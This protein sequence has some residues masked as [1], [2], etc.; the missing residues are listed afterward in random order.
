VN[1][2]HEVTSWEELGQWCWV[3]M[4]CLR[5]IWQTAPS[6]RRELPSTKLERSIDSCIRSMLR[7]PAHSLVA[8]EEDKPWILARLQFGSGL[9]QPS[10]VELLRL[11]KLSDPVDALRFLLL[12][13]WYD[14]GREFWPLVCDT[15]NEHDNAFSGEDGA[16]R[17]LSEVNPRDEDVD[18]KPLFFRSISSCQL[19][20]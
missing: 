13:E 20:A 16:R 19:H 1:E 7:S 2:L 11:P 17:S 3:R 10:N 5:R 12:E 4:L 15:I 8:P 18:R 9:V 6:F 14:S